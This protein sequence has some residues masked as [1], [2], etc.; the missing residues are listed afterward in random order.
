MTNE[1][2]PPALAGQ[3]ERG[4]RPA[5]PKRADFD[6]PHEVG[7]VDCA[8][9]ARALELMPEYSAIPAEFKNDSNPWAQ[10]QSDWFFGGL[11]KMPEPKS[12]IDLNS[13]IRHLHVIQGSFASKH[14][15]KQA[16][17]AFLASRWFERA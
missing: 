9:P 17:V 3:V 2:P 16:A 7:D 10:W 14:E 1:T 8:F 5:A 11:K 13:A 4:V 12:D 6:K 15:H